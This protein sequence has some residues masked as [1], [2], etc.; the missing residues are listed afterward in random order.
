MFASLPRRAAPAR[1]MPAR[2]IR[3]RRAADGDA[4]DGDA[5]Q[6]RGQALVE[7]AAVLLP[8][9]LV[10]V[11]IIQFGLIFNAN[12]TIT[13]AAREGARAA[14][15]YVYTTEP[16]TSRTTNDIDRCTAARTAATQAFGLLSP[17]SP[18]FTGSASCASG[19]DLNGDGMQD[20]WV[21]GD[22]AMSLCRRMATSSASCPS[23][24]DATSYCTQTDA[25]G[26]LVRV[27]LTYRADIIV[28]LI[29]ALLPTDGNG[30]FVQRAVATMVVN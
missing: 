10:V 6:P 14:T 25:A 7:F 17:T 3:R 23:S 27:E 24:S 1:A 8:I 11:G 19:T 15:I 5:P 29:S 13:N 20:R 2:V 28:P 22:V 18:N 12:V 21:N 16:G 9:L 4:A 30:R 26:C